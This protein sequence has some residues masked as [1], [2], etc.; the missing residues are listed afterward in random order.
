MYQKYG[1]KIYFLTTGVVTS[2]LYPNFYP[3]NLDKTEKIGV[4]SGQILKLEFTH[5][6][7]WTCGDIKNCPCD[8]IKIIDGDG[9]TLMD[10]SCGYSNRHPTSSLYFVPPIITTRTNTV[11]IFFHTND[12]YAQP[13]WNLTWTAI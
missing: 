3:D 11:E 12:D 13:G 1:S 4:E 10:K 2:P 5:F 8:Y 9:T 6:E 7:I